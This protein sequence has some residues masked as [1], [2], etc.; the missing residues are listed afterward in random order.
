M[1]LYYIGQDL[2]KHTE[3]ESDTYQIKKNQTENVKYNL[4]KFDLIGFGIYFSPSIYTMSEN[5]VQMSFLPITFF[6]FDDLECSNLD[7][8]LA[9]DLHTLVR[10]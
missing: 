10:I 9:I 2:I 3:I 5:I 8:L 1:S 7:V 6:C 4:I